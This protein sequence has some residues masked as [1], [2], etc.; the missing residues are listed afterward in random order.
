MSMDAVAACRWGGAFDG[1]LAYGT[2]SAL[3][4]VIQKLSAPADTER[5]YDNW[6]FSNSCGGVSNGSS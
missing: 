6:N 5:D 3:R 4:V 1:R 2:E